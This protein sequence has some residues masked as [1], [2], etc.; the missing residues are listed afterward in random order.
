MTASQRPDSGF[1]WGD[2]STMPLT[3]RRRS[4]GSLRRRRLGRIRVRRGARFVFTPPPPGNQSR[5]V[6]IQDKT[7][8]IHPRTLDVRHIWPGASGIRESPRGSRLVTRRLRTGRGCCSAVVGHSTP[9]VGRCAPGVGRSGAAVGR[10]GAVVGRSGAV[11]GRSGAVVGPCGDNHLANRHE[12]LAR[13]NG[14]VARFRTCLAY[15]RDRATTL[16]AQVT[17]LRAHLAWLGVHATSRERRPRLHALTSSKA[18]AHEENGRYGHVRRT[19][20]RTGEH[21]IHVVARI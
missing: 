6:T 11:V 10:S 19:S 15:H 1:T 2:V 13:R 14:F 4:R 12:R 7:V 18:S 8:M 9:G 17:H 3:N 21:A 5:G 20:C 16:D